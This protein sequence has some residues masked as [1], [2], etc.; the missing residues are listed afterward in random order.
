MKLEDKINRTDFVI[1]NDGS[2]EETKSHVTAVLSEIREK[3]GV[4][5]HI[6][7]ILTVITFAV[8]IVIQRIFA[9]MFG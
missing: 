3:S 6:H 9:R 2:V 5:K 1:D 8:L 4:W 7:G